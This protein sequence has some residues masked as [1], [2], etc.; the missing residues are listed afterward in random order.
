MKKNCKMNPKSLYIENPNHLVHTLFLTSYSFNN[1]ISLEK[2][3][4]IVLTMC[5]FR[6]YENLSLKTLIVSFATIIC[7]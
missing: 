1:L 7:P 4:T 5:R 6:F 3:I 2:E